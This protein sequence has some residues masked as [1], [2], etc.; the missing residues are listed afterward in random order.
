MVR[1]ND[2]RDT[3]VEWKRGYTA[4]SLSRSSLLEQVISSVHLSINKIISCKFFEAEAILHVSVQLL[5]QQS[6]MGL[7]D[8]INSSVSI[9]REH[10]ETGYETNSSKSLKQ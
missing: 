2:L 6:Q 7:A 9:E 5:A 3:R 1:Q 4:S 8:H 10:V